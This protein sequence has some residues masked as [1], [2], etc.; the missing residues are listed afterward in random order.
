MYSGQTRPTVEYDRQIRYLDYMENGQ[1]CRGAGFVKLE[2]S[3]DRCNISLQ[4]SG[5]YRKDCFTRPLYLLSGNEERELCKLQLANGGIKTYLEGLNSHDL[6]GQGLDYKQLTGLRIPIS[7]SKEILCLWAA[8][9]TRGSRMSHSPEREPEMQAEKAAGQ[10]GEAGQ[11]GRQTEETEERAGKAGQADR[12]VDR[13]IEGRTA[14]QV[15]GQTPE[16]E[17]WTGERDEGTDTAP[18]AFREDKWEQLWA[19]YPHINPFSDEREYLSLGPSD[20]V[21]LPGSYYKLVNNSFLLHGYYNYHHLILARVRHRNSVYY[22]IGVPGNLYQREKKIA[23]MFGFE[24]FEC[25]AE[26]AG[27]GAFGY[28]LIPVEL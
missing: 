12:Q 9:E 10:A 16:I 3:D 18:V 26:P 13:Q 11:A 6:D 19:I 5:L 8:S 22:Y 17:T 14:G 4:I 28:Y 27:D 7:E 25:A 1:R 21:I 15:E 2:R 24:G 23:I 20:F